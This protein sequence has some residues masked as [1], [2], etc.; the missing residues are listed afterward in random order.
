MILCL[1]LSGCG[2]GPD[3]GRVA[4]ALDLCST[5]PTVKVGLVAPF[6]GRYRSQGYEALYAVKLAVRERNAA[7]GVSGYMVEL[8]ALDDGE[9]PE[10]R[11]FLAQKFAVDERV[12]GVVGPF[13]ADSLFDV[14]SA[15]REAGLPLITPAMCPSPESGSSGEAFCLGADAERVAETLAQAVPGASPAVVLR[16]PYAGWD[17]WVDHLPDLDWEIR[18]S[19]E[20]R[21]ATAEYYLYD[22]DVLG[23]AELLSEMRA[24]GVNA[25][26]FGGPMLARTQLSQIAGDAVQGAC[27]AMTA[28]LYADQASFFARGYRELG[29]GTPGPWAVLAYDATVLLLDALEREIASSGR[30]TREDVGAA[31]TQARGLDGELFF[32]NHRRRRAEMR[33][34]CYQAGESYPGSVV[35]RR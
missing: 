32:E 33:L 5:L 16:S 24:E 35:S 34:Y 1:I 9:A 17:S 21:S 15:Y 13:S 4:R 29:G 7:G 26:L 18:A 3:C 19:D 14:A 2:A 30:P 10:A 27:Y 28:P 20:W 23:A 25:P 31:L 12:M 11:R 6:E 8:V 22:G